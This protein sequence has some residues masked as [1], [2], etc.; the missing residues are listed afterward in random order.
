MKSKSVP[1]LCGGIF[2]GLLFEARKPSRKARNRLK[3][4]S[5]GLSLPNIYA[6]LIEVVTGEDLTSTAGNTLR[7]CATNYRKCENSSGDYVPFTRVSTQ[8]AFRFKYA[9]EK[10]QLLER[11]AKFVEKYLNKDKCV[12][13]VSALIETIQSDKTISE[14]TLIAINYDECVSV[15]ELHTVK[16]IILLPF[17]LSVL[18]YIVIKCPDCES[19]KNTFLAWY[20]QS[21]PNAEWKFNSTIGST[22]T[23]LE[24]DTNLSIPDKGTAQDE[25]TIEQPNDLCQTDADVIRDQV[26]GIGK[27]MNIVF[28]VAQH[29]LAEEIRQ[30]KQPHQKDESATVE[31]ETIEDKK[32]PTS[33]DDKKRVINQTVVNQYGDHPVHIEYVDKLEF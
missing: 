7:K 27:T 24:V 1:H 28:G 23:L 13:L 21:K 3:G 18:Y 16:K 30:K 20:S 29:E 25:C 9:T 10:S 4:G 11:M 14:N 22:T 5:D 32:D 6:G 8:N 31:T 15:K 17:L 2:F 19:G 33:T 26:M 12:W